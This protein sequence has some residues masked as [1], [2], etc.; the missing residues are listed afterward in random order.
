MKNR[1]QLEADRDQLAPRP[2]TALTPL[3]PLTRRPTP[4]PHPM[5]QVERSI[6]RVFTRGPEPATVPSTLAE[7]PPRPKVER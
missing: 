3:T 4:A 7:R 6:V 2:V 1:S 5:S